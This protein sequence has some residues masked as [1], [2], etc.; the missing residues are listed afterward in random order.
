MHTRVGRIRH[1]KFY[2]RV[3]QNHPAVVM[4]SM[5]HNGTGYSEDM[6]PDMIDGIHD[7]RTGGALRNA[8]RAMRA[9]TIVKDFVR[10]A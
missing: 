5:S 1:A 3:A 9:E 4:Y 10:A 7:A 2:V 8:Q 6:N